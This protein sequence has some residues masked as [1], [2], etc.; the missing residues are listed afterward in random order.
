MKNKGAKSKSEDIFE[1]FDAMKNGSTITDNSDEAKG[2]ET[3]VKKNQ[4]RQRQVL[5]R[6]TCFPKITGQA[7]TKSL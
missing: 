1:Q 5:S 7:K 3:G 6:K 4:V 2:D